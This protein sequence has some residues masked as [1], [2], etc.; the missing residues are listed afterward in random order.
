MEHETIPQERLER[1][2][3]MMCDDFCKWPIESTNED[4]LELHCE[5]CPLRHIKDDDFWEK[6]AGDD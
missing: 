2:Q 1:C 5:E 4:T 3:E 6:G